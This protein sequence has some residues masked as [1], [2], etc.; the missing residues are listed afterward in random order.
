MN[1]PNWAMKTGRV[2]TVYGW[3]YDFEEAP[4]DLE[5]TRISFKFPDTTQRDNFIKNIG[6]L[7]DIEKEY[8]IGLTEILS[9]QNEKV[10]VIEGDKVWQSNCWKMSMYMMYLRRIAHDNPAKPIFDSSDAS[11]IRFFKH[12]GNC[13][14]ILMTY[15]HES[16][17]E[18]QNEW[19]VNQ[20]HS[21][22]GGRSM[23]EYRS[24]LNA[25]DAHTYLEPWQ[26]RACQMVN[27]VNPNF[28]QLK[29]AA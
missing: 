17:D 14:K 9:T 13:D 22:S 29:E 7:N 25:E 12:N 6:Y 11:A 21:S 20:A 5:V 16:F 28:K 27:V 3:T 1:V 10:L 4:Y 19:L 23:G 26:L 18:Y 8:G 15:I 24:Y 2:D